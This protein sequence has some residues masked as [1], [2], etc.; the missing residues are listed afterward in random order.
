MSDLQPMGLLIGIYC[1]ILRLLSLG[2]ILMGLP[3]LLI[4]SFLQN[5]Q[6]FYMVSIVSI[7]SHILCF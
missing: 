6:S 4:R 5:R 1:V 7:G 3:N 2:E